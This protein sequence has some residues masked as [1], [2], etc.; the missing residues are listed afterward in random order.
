MQDVQASLALQALLNPL[1]HLE[2]RAELPSSS[3]FY[4]TAA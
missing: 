1:A 3:L 2:E 4:F